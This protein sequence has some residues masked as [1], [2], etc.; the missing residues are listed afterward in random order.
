MQKKK[1]SDKASWIT[2]TPAE[3]KKKELKVL[4]SLNRVKSAQEFPTSQNS[5]FV[6]Y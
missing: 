1:K 4:M 3:I 2:R 5:V 6:N